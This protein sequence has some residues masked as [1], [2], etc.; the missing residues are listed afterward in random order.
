VGVATHGQATIP[1]K[2]Q[3][4]VGTLKKGDEAAGRSG[5][6]HTKRLH[7][8]VDMPGKAERPKDRCGAT[9]PSKPPATSQLA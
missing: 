4:S 5:D 3:D 2:L 9:A 6:G 1:P 8:I 7:A